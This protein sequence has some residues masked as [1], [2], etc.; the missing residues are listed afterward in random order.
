MKDTKHDPSCEF[1]LDGNAAAGLLQEIFGAE[2]T[3]NRV[4]C[5]HCG[6]VTML[7]AM[8]LFGGEMGSVLR[9]PWCQGVMMRLLER[10]DDFWLDMQ[11]I[12]YLRLKKD[13]L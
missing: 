8:L 6:K 11:G 9:C 4:R 3:T 10:D 12:S 2:M 5:A 1:M 13:A 7:G